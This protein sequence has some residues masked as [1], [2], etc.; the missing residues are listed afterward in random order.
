MTTSLILPESLL[1]KIACFLPLRERLALS[2]TSKSYK[3]L[4]RSYS[5]ISV[6]LAE[7][8]KTGRCKVYSWEIAFVLEQTVGQEQVLSL[9]NE[10][11]IG[12]V[13]DTNETLGSL[14]KRFQ[15]V[16]VVSV[17]IR[18]RCLSIFHLYDYDVRRSPFDQF[19]DD[20]EF[21]LETV[22]AN[23][24]NLKFVSPRLKDDYNVV[25]EAV[26]KDGELISSASIRLRGN[27]S[28]CKAALQNQSWTAVYHYFRN[29]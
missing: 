13:L 15:S 25:L 5:F 7:Q 3:K 28:V 9:S 26:G 21:V 16:N 18:N 10:L 23:P 22:R 17:L 11:A 20:K 24:A 12:L 14:Q 6:L 2:T 29:V 19:I 27:Y 8:K 1:G 4:V